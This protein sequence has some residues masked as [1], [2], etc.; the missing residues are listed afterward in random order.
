MAL[1]FHWLL[2]NLNHLRFQILL[3]L[4][5]LFS[6]IPLACVIDILIVSLISLTLLCVFHPFCLSMSHSD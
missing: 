6:G 1:I 3:L 4:H 5:P 2:K